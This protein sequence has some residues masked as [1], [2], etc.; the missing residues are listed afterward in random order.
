MNPATSTAR[1]IAP[2]SETTAIERRRHARVAMERHGKLRHS[3]SGHYFAVDTI[4]VS[5]GG[6]LLRLGEQAPLLP[7]DTVALG[8]AWAGEH[9]LDDNAM[10]PATV[11]RVTDRGRRSTAV[12]VRFATPRRAPLPR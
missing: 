4:D 6:A 2:A 9:I 3:A 1:R 8:V 7:G 10:T 12:A 5:S 11:I